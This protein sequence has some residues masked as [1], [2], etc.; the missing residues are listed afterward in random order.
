MRIMEASVG[1]SPYRAEEALLVLHAVGCRLVVAKQLPLGSRLARS[2]YRWTT[3][4]AAETCPQ[5]VSRA[6][7][8]LSFKEVC[9]GGSIE[10][11]RPFQGAALYTDRAI[12]RTPE[13]Y[14]KATSQKGNFQIT[15][16]PRFGSV[17]VG[18]YCGRFG[19]RKG[20]L[21]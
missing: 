2:M 11:A 18:S 5:L 14:G 3:V 15:V 21:Y 12:L 7:A 6:F 8:V 10:S 13:T 9:S 16:T 20:R 1:A 19:F 17:R 4:L